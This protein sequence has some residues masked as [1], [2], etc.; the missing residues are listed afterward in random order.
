[1]WG[2]APALLALT[3]HVVLSHGH[4]DHTGGFRDLVETIGNS[5]TLAIKPELL[6]PK[7]AYNNGSLQFNGNNFNQQY[8]LEKKINTKY[9]D[10]DVVEILPDLYVL[11]NFQRLTDFEEENPRF[12]LYSGKE[13]VTDCFKDEL[14]MVI[15]R[16]QGLTVLL[17]CSHPGV[18]NILKT[19][20]DRFDRPIYAILGGS[21]L[22]GADKKRLEGTVALLKAI[23]PTLLGL[24]HCTGEKA[25]QY[26][27]ENFGQFFI[28][29]TGTSIKID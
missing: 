5:F 9:I 14:V 19:I 24:S 22:I 25:T 8:L 20:I 7:Y 2:K 3:S 26:L 18:I 10:E 1:M 12:C 16:P 13:L 15:N 27:M 4:Y 11:G 21:H 6:V 23:N 17:G 29:S 28:N